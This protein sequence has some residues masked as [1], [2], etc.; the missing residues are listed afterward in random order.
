MVG[1]PNEFYSLEEKEVMA[2]ILADR[3]EKVTL[4]CNECGKKRKVSPDGNYNERC[5]KC[6]GVDWDVL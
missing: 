4:Q 2:E 5:P 6:G 1:N 3:A